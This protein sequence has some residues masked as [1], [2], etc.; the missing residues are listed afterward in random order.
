MDVSI[1]NKLPGRI[2]G[3]TPLEGPYADVAVNLGST[4]LRALVT[5]ESCDRLGLQT[6]TAVWAMVKSVALDSR[7]V[8]FNRRLRPDRAD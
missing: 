8:G 4:S 3:I 7:S 5:R 6:G 1:S 2:A